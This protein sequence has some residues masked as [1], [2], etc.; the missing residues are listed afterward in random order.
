LK[1]KY[2]KRSSEKWFSDDL[3]ILKPKLK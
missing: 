1:R 3:Q 2:E